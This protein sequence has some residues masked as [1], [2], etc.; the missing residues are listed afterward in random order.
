MADLVQ[1]DRLEIEAVRLAARRH[2]PR[3][4]RVEEDVRFDELAAH[5]IEREARRAEHAIEFRMALEAEHAMSS[6]S[7]GRAPLKPTRSK[8][9]DEV[10]TASHVAK[11][12]PTV[13]SSCAVDTPGTACRSETK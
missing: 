5:G 9:I 13:V 1:R 3:E 8:R 4:R 2:R 12:R 7:P 6:S 10:D 11:A